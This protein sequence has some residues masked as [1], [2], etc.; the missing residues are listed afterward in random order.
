MGYDNRGNTRSFDTRYGV[1]KL[2]A[3]AMVFSRS[4]PRSG[5]GTASAS[6][7]QNNPEVTARTTL[8]AN[9]RKTYLVPADFYDA[10]LDKQI[11]LYARGPW[12]D[13]LALN[14]AGFSE[15][16]AIEGYFPCGVPL[17]LVA[18]VAWRRY[19]SCADSDVV[20]S[21]GNMLLNSRIVFTKAVL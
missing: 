19:Y 21:Q 20:L 6:S 2:V 10:D 7:N 14:T 9:G 3:V 16:Y 15:R 12:F 5:S 8:E 4:T 17:T 18:A 1:G 13:T 11:E